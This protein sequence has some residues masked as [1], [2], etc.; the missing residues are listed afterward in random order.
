[1]AASGVQFC[2]RTR[3]AIVSNQF[4]MALGHSRSNISKACA[5]LY[6]EMQTLVNF[7]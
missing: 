3:G 1:V 7:N 6:G 2:V 4:C 5:F